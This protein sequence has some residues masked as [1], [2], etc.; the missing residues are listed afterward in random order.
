MLYIVLYC[1]SNNPLH[2]QRENV[3]A[4]KAVIEAEA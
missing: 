1:I 4:V 3:A 2:F